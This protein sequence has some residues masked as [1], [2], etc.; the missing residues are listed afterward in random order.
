MQTVSTKPPTLSP[1][2]ERL[3]LVPLFALPGLWL[4]G[5]FFPPLNHDVAVLLDVSGR[6]VALKGLLERTGLAPDDL[7][8]VILGHCYP[9]MEA[10]AI[11]RVVA[12]DA[13]LPVTGECDAATQSKLK[14]MHGS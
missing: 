1:R 11:G 14:E 9:S 2:I 6:W 7:E 5:Y 8:D 13:G 3:L 12:L 4:V 10:P